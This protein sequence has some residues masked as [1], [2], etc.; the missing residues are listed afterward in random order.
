MARMLPP[1]GQVL[2]QC[3]A[4]NSRLGQK[5]GVKDM[6]R[7]VAIGGRA[8]QNVAWRAANGILHAG[9]P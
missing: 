9:L 3:T 8:T 7:T 6:V 2:G 5:Q 1:C 4:G